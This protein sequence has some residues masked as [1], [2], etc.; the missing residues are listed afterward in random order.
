M[1][2]KVR[3]KLPEPK[4]FFQEF[5]A[6]RGDWE[7]EPVVTTC[8][9]FDG[10]RFSRG[11]AVLGEEDVP[12]R[13]KAKVQAKANALRALLG[14]EIKKPVTDPRAISRLMETD[15]PFTMHIDL[16]PQLSFKEI[17]GLFK[18][19]KKHILVFSRHCNGGS[20]ETVLWNAG[21]ERNTEVM[22]K[23]VLARVAPM[24][25]TDK[26]LEISEAKPVPLFG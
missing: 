8:I 15:C 9:A 14:R 22:D 23:R 17:A 3:N 13:E 12:D 26:F 10:Y 1:E 7:G 20:K 25:T 21:G 24:L 11:M 2:I 19:D 6:Q 5:I 4:F 18:K 16:E